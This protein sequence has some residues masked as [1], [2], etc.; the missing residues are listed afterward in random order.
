M[1]VLCGLQ[2]VFFLFNCQT[3]EYAECAGRRTIQK[4]NLEYF[5]VSGIINSYRKSL[6]RIEYTGERKGF[7][8]LSVKGEQQGRY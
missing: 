1:Q 4:I 6:S 8:L 7:L 3:P 2:V 5:Q